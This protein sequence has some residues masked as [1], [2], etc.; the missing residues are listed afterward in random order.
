[1]SYCEP[2]NVTASNRFYYSPHFWLI[3]GIILLITIANYGKT[4]PALQS[5]TPGSE[6]GLSGLVMGY[7]LYLIPTFYSYFIFGLRGS[8]LVL[9][10]FLLTMLPEAAF[11]SEYPTKSFLAVSGAAL[12]GSTILFLS[13]LYKRQRSEIKITRERLELAHRKLHSRAKNAIEH[14]DRMAALTAFSAMLNQSLDIGEVIKTGIKMVVEVMQVEVVILFSLDAKNEEL[15]V[16]AFEGVDYKY[17]AVVDRIKLGR[18]FCGR[19]AAT[20]QPLLVE[21]IAVDPV[22][23]SR[24]AMDEQLQTQLSVPLQSRGNIIGTLC[25]ATRSPR[26]FTYSEIELLTAIGNLIGIAIENSELSLERELAAEQLAISEKKYRQLFENAHDAIWVQDLSGKI[27]AANKAAA[28]L[29]G[30]TLP[31]LVGTYIQDHL[32][33]EGLYLSRKMQDKLLKGQITKQP[34]TQK[35]IKKDGTEAMLMLTSNIISSNGQPDGIQFIGR[36]ITNEVRMQENQQFY[37]Q[38]ITQAHEEERLRISRDLHDSSAQNL[39]GILHKLENFCQNDEYL[40]MPKLRSLWSLHERLKD[41]LQEIRQL[42]RDLRPSILDHLGLLAAVD[43]LAEQL[44]SEHKIDAR[45]T[46]E[47]KERRFTPETEVALFRI[48]QEALRNVAKHSG[49]TKAMINVNFKQDETVITVIDNGKGFDQP[50]S[51]GELSRKGKLG[52]DGMQTRARLIG[53]TFKIKS[54]VG[55]GSVLSIRIPS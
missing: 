5:L 44:K 31:E 47:G 45:L 34:Y 1:M 37:L 54:G 11:L 7:T 50:E 17:A 51:L 24:E 41:V 18:G 19:V 25:V 21:N 20:G 55:K 6:P 27:T 30:C 16:I 48:V 52:L 15:R 33:Q 46:V 3:A 32:P 36:D 22:H 14:E 42:S 8:L 53:G 4:I 40:P 49:A 23:G 10:I 12:G 38:Q 28:A 43:W 13:D 2:E 26:Q 9:A 39:I 29:F 35:V